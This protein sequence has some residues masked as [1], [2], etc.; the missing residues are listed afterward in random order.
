MELPADVGQQ[1]CFPR[2]TLTL[3]APPPAAG[4]PPGRAAARHR[5]GRR[6]AQ[7][8]VPF[9]FDWRA[10]GKVPAVRDQVR[11]SCG[12]VGSRCGWRALAAQGASE[13][14]GGRGSWPVRP[15]LVAAAPAVTPAAAAPR[16]SLL[17][18]GNCG[19]GWAFA[20]V[21]ALEIKVI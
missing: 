5:P 19:S 21:S 16:A 17:L 3:H 18:Q 11:R 15:G 13:A 9:A 12:V 1:P 14:R 20:A 7:A 2:R 10:Q 4:P 8:G 6:L